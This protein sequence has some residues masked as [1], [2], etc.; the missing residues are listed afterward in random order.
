MAIGTPGGLD[1]WGFRPSRKPPRD[2][3]A[4]LLNRIK[5]PSYT[6]KAPPVTVKVSL[7]GGRSRIPDP[8]CPR[9]L[10]V[11]LRH[12]QYY[13]KLISLRFRLTLRG[14]S[15]MGEAY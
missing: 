13:L 11:A 7:P 5:M 8:F 4:D 15:A 1:L 2:I 12:N 14:N 6:R 3:F 10:W 9:G